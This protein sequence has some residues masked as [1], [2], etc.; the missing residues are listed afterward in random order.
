MISVTSAILGCQ[1]KS[2][3]AL[4]ALLT[5]AAGSPD[6]RFPRTIGISR[7]VTRHAVS[8]TSRTEKP[9]SMP[10]LYAPDRRPPSECLQCLHMRI[11]QIGKMDVIANAG[12]VG[13]GVV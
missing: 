4:V 12:P 13:G 1:S 6:R 7:S 5:R 8:T 2:F 11:R 9:R 10:R 3:F